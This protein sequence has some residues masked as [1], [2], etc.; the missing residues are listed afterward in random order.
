MH[1]LM[2]VTIACLLYMLLHPIAAEQQ[3]LLTNAEVSDLNQHTVW[4]GNKN[5]V[6][7][8]GFKSF[9]H[10]NPTGDGSQEL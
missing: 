5:S 9:A 6:I 1:Y 3:S 8:A 2:V 4:T 7:S 10:F